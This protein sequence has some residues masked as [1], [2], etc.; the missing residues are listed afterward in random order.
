M[1][2][3]VYAAH[4]PELVRYCTGL[5]RDT[6]LAEDLAQE[7]FLRA[8]RAGDDFLE[9]GPSQRRAWLYRAL[10]NLLTDTLRHTAMEGRY[11]PILEAGVDETASEPGFEGVEAA[12]VLQL[13]PA[14]DQVLFRM[15]YLEGYTAA[16]LAELFRLPPGTVR[17]RLCR[18]RRLLKKFLEN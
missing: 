11:A 6:P 7:V 16:E 12:L 14:E 10:K 5:C 3:E 9:L 1:W 2:E 18:S 8:L 4:Y 15:R 17:S 13:L